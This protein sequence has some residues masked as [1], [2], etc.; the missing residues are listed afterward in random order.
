MY[1]DSRFV[2]EGDTFIALEESEQY[3][4]FIRNSYRITRQMTMINFAYNKIHSFV[5]YV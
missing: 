5:T 1:R 3:K 2:L 4:Y